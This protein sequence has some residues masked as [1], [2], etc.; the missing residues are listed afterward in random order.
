MAPEDVIRH[1]PVAAVL[2]EARS[3]R[4]VHANARALQMVER[5]LGRTLPEQLEADWEIFRPDGQPYE[6]EEWPL[7]RS[8]T[9]GEEVTDERYY[10]VLPDGSRLF[11]R[12]SSAP[13]YDG[14][15]IVGGLLVMEDVTAERRAEQQ[16][17]QQAILAD[18][19]ADAVVGTDP[20]FRVTVWN[21]A[22][23]RLYGFAADEVLGS[24]AR[25]VASYEG[26][27]SRLQ[28]EA[29][30]LDTDRTR[31]EVRA[32]RKDGTRIDVELISVAVRDQ[33]GEITGYLGIHRDI[34]ERKRA[35]Q[36]L[37]AA[38]GR[39]QTIL[40]SIGDTFFHVDSQWRYTYLNQRAL[41][42]ARQAR[43]PDLMLD[44]LLGKSCWE[45]FPEMVNTMFHR[46]FHR[47]VREQ[48]SLTFEAY[49]PAT[50]T[51]EE[52]RAYPV[53]GGLSVYSRDVTLR[54]RA[55]QE[56]HDRAEEQALIAELGLRAL[57]T[58]D[59]DPVL[60]EAAEFL[61]QM[62]DVELT[63]IAELLPGEGEIHLRAGVGWHEAVIG[64][65]NEPAPAESQW[66]Y[67]VGA[68]DA[69]ISEDL[70]AEQR[71]I[72]SPVALANGAV[73]WAGVVIHGRDRPFGVLGALAKRRRMFSGRERRFMQAVA[74][75]VALAVQRV[76]SERRII[77]VRDNE[78][79]R[80]ARD[81]HDEAL[82]DLTDAQAQASM[83]S[84]GEGD[85]EERLERLA[86]ALRRVGAQL[87]GAIYDLRLAGEDNRPFPE[88]LTALVELQGAM[89][90]GCEIELDVGEGT[91]AGPLG[92]R[93]TE[94]LRIV[95]E[96][97]VNARR[98]AD[99]RR[100]RVAASGSGKQLSIEIS[101]DGGGFD[102]ARTLT[103]ARGVGLMGMR[104]RAALLEGELEIR[105]EPRAGTV[106]GL[107]VPLAR[108]RSRASRA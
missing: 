16:R 33:A 32:Y 7:V 53:E 85:A 103:A 30:L 56:M 107:S 94:I 9:F 89:C 79:R 52:T 28:L 78:R 49:S 97:I 55:E 80:I 46:E 25:E 106:V 51:W 31:A 5:Q 42:W 38:R 54:K 50:D 20:L 100:I 87:R 82:Q 3:G 76:D 27:Q 14:A 17:A 70:P 72:P 105:S 71:F 35:E 96:A 84:P 73:S 91:P 26:D 62:L 77:E 57:A 98:H 81:L 66:G 108:E 43:G 37:E 29:Q 59:L 13:I 75:V 34:T 90:D 39:S 104:E 48:Q 1:I 68:G 64:T 93:G 12:C 8:M 63:A 36:A 86:P 45:L 23:E 2:V 21:E 58:D 83:A 11:V 6:M 22:A 65:L 10:N 19:L 99:A 61:A 40:E 44:D 69:V 101:D 74:S 102:A 15:E 4:I 24:D 47:A 67:T 92:N 18:H 88:L 95:G 41:A 60:E